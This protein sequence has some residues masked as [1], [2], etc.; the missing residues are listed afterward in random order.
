M[1]M[2]HARSTSREI[3]EYTQKMVAQDAAKGAK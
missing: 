2:I 1:D 3:A